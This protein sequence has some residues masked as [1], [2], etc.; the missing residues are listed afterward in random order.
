MRI[1]MLK[2]RRNFKYLINIYS[3]IK[4]YEKFGIEGLLDKRGK[5]RNK[6]EMSEIEILKAKNKLLESENLRKQMEID[7][8]KK[9]DEIERRRF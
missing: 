6:N 2:Q 4:K 3:W 7:F 5:R 9:L 1:I 8:L